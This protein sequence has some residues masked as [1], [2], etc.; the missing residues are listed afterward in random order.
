[1]Y[2]LDEPHVRVGEVRLELTPS[3]PA[4]L[5]VYL[6][7]QGAWVE[8]DSLADLLWPDSPEEEARHNLRVNLHRARSLPW[9]T[10]LEVERD[11]LRFPIE[12]DVAQ[13]RAALGRADWAAAV[14]LH[15]RPFLQG[16][17]WQNTPA[18]E[19]WAALERESLLEAWQN[20]AQRHAEALQQAQQHPEASRL[21]AEIL[22]HNLLAE[23]VLQNYMR[24]AYL[25]GQREA[26]LRLY[27]R[28]V[29]ELKHELGL[30]PMRATQELAASLRRAEPLQVASP[31]PP[32]RI[33]LEVL[34]PPRLVG[35]EAEQARLRDS[36]ALLVHGEPGVG[37]TRLLQEVFPD[38]PL[39]RCREGLENVPFYP[40]LEYLKAHLEALPDLGPYREDLARL[41]PEVYPG[42]TP[43]PAEP[44]SAKT[45]LL[46]ALA[47][48]LAPAG[49]LLF[50]DLQWADESTLELLLYLHSRGQ[51]WTGAY[52]THEV[53]PALAKAREALRGSGAAELALEPLGA[54]AVQTLL[55]DLIG[56]PQGPPLFSSWL[57]GQ[58]GGNP[59][60]ALETLKA[61][62][63][64]GVLRAEGGQ[65]HTDLD[66]ITQDYSELQIP[67]RVAEVV[68]RRVGRLS[69]PAQ[70]VVQAASVVG[71][72]FT[73][74][75]LSE[76]TGLSEWVVLEGIE[77][78]EQT[79]MLAG[80]R[81]VHDML[82]QG[83]YQGISDSR[84]KAVH[85]KVAE[86]LEPAASPQLVAEHWIRA[87]DVAKAITFWRIAARRLT[88]LSF[89]QE[90]L[91][92]NQRALQHNTDPRLAQELQIDIGINLFSLSQEAA[93]VS[94]WQSVLENSQDIQI[95]ARA[96][97]QLAAHHTLIGQMSE[98]KQ[99]L[100]Q[101]H[102]LG[103]FDTL[104]REHQQ[105]VLREM[106][107]I[108]VR[109][110]RF[111][112][113]LDLAYQRLKYFNQDENSVQVAS[114]LS[115]IGTILV[116]LGRKEEALEALERSLA[117]HQ[118]I[119]SRDGLMQA[120]G[121][122]L[123]YWI[124]VGEPARGLVLAEKTL[125]LDT[126]NSFSHTEALRN[127]VANAYARMG[128]AAKAILHYEINALRAKNP[129]WKAAAWATLARLYQE[130]GRGQ[131]VMG[132][133]DKAIESIAKVEFAAPRA[134][135]LIAALNYGTT[136]QIQAA[137]KL[138]GSLKTEAL[139]PHLQAQLEQAQA[140]YDARIQS[141]KG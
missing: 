51:P 30:E 3:R 112:E 44:S 92:L 77:Q 33:P 37:K 75:L 67:P 118:T 1:L 125:E 27:E 4:Y 46:E 76:V 117:M 50:D 26:A 102:Q 38:S 28:F 5:L 101:I 130:T 66:E 9:A 25:A 103:A 40:V 29:Q 70:R 78:A 139:P 16:F 100:D 79:G 35:R 17:P 108:A 131:E 2:L 52:R 64:N 39:L 104:T 124:T 73:P 36:T 106:Q 135:V 43:P 105:E 95:R 24:A 136:G 109:E 123:Y 138:T 82:R 116:N 19:D 58:T 14:R 98:A 12:T 10:G 55:A 59:F 57:H 8:R 71:E 97:T 80:T 18:L 56:T 68:R 11:R 99:I 34:R 96:L 94:L 74:R 83:V 60:F 45:R 88:E 47:R 32:P 63:E 72:G 62:F 141:S 86:R 114:L 126:E 89:D 7:C 15:R 69:E 133:V 84:R 53:G 21:L 137:H 121:N 128:E 42:F 107:R 20:A 129:I 49:R 127:N 119:G 111:Q 81:F 120:A 87:G 41:L 122:L 6:A 132:A 91:L 13:F 134:L 48:A 93:A 85:A 90:A 65:W 113:A 61:L 31:K 54:D 115:E 140:E 110:G 23:D 22:R